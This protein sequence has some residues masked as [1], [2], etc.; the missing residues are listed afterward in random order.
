MSNKTPTLDYA[1]ETR[2]RPWHPLGNVFAYM[3]GIIVVL[4]VVIGLMLL[5]FVFALL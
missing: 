3:A 5:G 1:T 2:L 4:G